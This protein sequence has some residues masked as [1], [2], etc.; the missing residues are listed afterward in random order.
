MKKVTYSYG[1]RALGYSEGEFFVSED[2]TNEE[3]EKQIEEEAG[4]GIY[5]NT[6]DG[7]EPRTEIVYEKVR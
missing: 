5:F 2:T 4:F 7:Y 1:C 3:I 6:E